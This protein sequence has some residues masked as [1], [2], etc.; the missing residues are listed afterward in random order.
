MNSEYIP[1]DEVIY[2]GLSF[3]DDGGR[4][5]KWNGEL[6]R[7]IPS[8]RASFCRHLFNKGIMREL[9]AKK[10]FV[11]TEITP[12]KC[13]HYEIILK[14]RTI[15]FVSYPQEWCDIMLKDAALH[16][17]YFCIELDRHKLL[18]EDAHP[19]NILFDGCQPF[20]VDF[21]SISPIP[22][23][24]THWEWF[25]HEQFSRAFV[26]PLRLMAQGHGRIAHWLQHD[27]ELGVLKSD[28]E[29]L[30]RRPLPGLNLVRNLVNRFKYSARLYAPEKTHKIVTKV[31]MIGKPHVPD[32]LNFLQARSDYFKQMRQEVENIKLPS[33]QLKIVNGSDGSLLP[34]LTSENWTNRHHMVSTVLSDLRPGSVLNIG[35]DAHRID[36]PLLAARYGR[37]V[38]AVNTDE[39]NIRNLY[40]VAKRN[41]L[42]II[43]LQINF[44]SPSYDLSNYWF[45]PA[46]QR[47]RCDLVLA[48]DL[49]HHLV[50]ENIRLSL[51]VERLSLLSNHWLLLEF[52]SLKDWE[53]SEVKAVQD[54]WYTLDNLRDE[55]TKWFRSIN[56]ISSQSKTRTLL[57]CE[58]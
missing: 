49:I 34:E 25:N 8:E 52:I 26:Y 22:V 40:V 2:Q 17:L 37:R 44:F 41:N 27:Y 20:F 30:T 47:L 13:D 42:P 53:S 16:H 12:L 55:L 10:L 29:A 43:P 4:L 1:Y 24:S 32:S 36:V 50:K 11:E 35:R 56:I 28:L 9:I 15:P 31:S 57:L 19:L 48:L 58:K 38:V 3:A 33:A 6:F 18:S 51:I 46:S 23:D 7:G 45:T 39:T 21:G 54:S 14:H 5:F